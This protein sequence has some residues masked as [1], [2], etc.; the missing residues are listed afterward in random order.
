LGLA[1]AQ[2]IWLPVNSGL[3]HPD[4]FSLVQH[5][6]FLYAGTGGGGCFR[7]ADGGATWTAVN[8]GLT[9]LTIFSFV[10]KGS[11]LFCGTVGGGVHVSSDNGLTWT[12][13]NTGLTNLLIFSL[14]TDGTTLYAGTVGGGVFRS[15]DNGATWSASNTGLTNF[16]VFSLLVHGSRMYATTNGDGLFISN[17]GGMTWSPSNTGLTSFATCTIIAAGSK[18]YLGTFGGGAFESNDG[19]ITWSGIPTFAGMQ[20][21]RFTATIPGVVYVGTGGGGVFRTTDGGATWSTLNTGLTN[22]NVWALYTA[23]GNNVFAGTLG[24][25]AHYLFDPPFITTF[26]PAFALTGQTVTIT[27]GNFFLVSAVS[28]GGV[29][30]ASFTV[31]DRNT[32]VATVGAGASGQVEVTTPL[33]TASL[34]NFIFGTPPPPSTTG[35]GG[36]GGTTGPPPIRVLSFFPPSGS[37][38]STIVI[39]GQN[40]TSAVQVAFGGVTARSFVVEND[41]TIRA[42]V[43]RGASG[44]ITVFQSS[45]QRD[46]SKTPFEYIPPPQPE[47]RAIAPDR[48]TFATG[49]RI[50]GKNFTGAVAVTFGSFP[51]LSFRVE[52]DSV[53]TAVVG[54]GVAGTTRVTVFT[55]RAFGSFDGFTYE[56]LPAPIITELLP[57]TI[58][59]N[60]EDFTVSVIGRHFFGT[61]STVTLNNVRGT[62]LSIGPTEAFVR[63]PGFLRRVGNAVLQ[64]TNPDEQFTTATLR[65]TPAPAPTITELSVVSTMATGQAFTVRLKG[66]GFFRSSIITVNNVPRL[67]VR[68][69][70]STTATFE[71]SASE[72]ITPT[73]AVIRVINPDQQAAAAFLTILGHPAP[74]IDRLSAQPSL[75]DTSSI[76][77]RVEGRNF[78]QPAI[79]ELSGVA[80]EQVSFSPTTIV[81]IVP[82]RLQRPAGQTGD[83]P[84]VVIVRNPD[85]QIAGTRWH[86]E[87]PPPFAITDVSP[88]QR[89]LD[90]T[91]GTL[92]FGLTIRGTSFLPGMTAFLDSWWPLVVLR[93]TDT[94][95]FIQLPVPLPPADA[96]G[97]RRLQLRNVNGGV[98][99]HRLRFVFNLSGVL[100]ASELLDTSIADVTT[101]ASASEVMSEAE[102]CFVPLQVRV[103]PN[104]AT[105]ELT[106]RL[107]PALSENDKFSRTARIVHAQVRSM[108]SGKIMLAELP[109]NTL[110][111]PSTANVSTIHALTFPVSTLPPG[112]YLVELTV[113]GQVVHAQR[114]GAM[115]SPLSTSPSSNDACHTFVARFV[116]Q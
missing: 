105:T 10:S 68:D 27:G 24:G 33:G 76:W 85:G 84:A 104:P 86:V 4:V 96:Q 80:L 108:S 93:Q 82:P 7:S 11:L 30:A 62:I 98:A 89:F 69:R 46:T 109:P 51:A 81:A 48:G 114:S 26:T 71:I 39:L 91:T 88:V 97:F 35:T 6:G 66:T 38:D 99:E 112:A 102:L 83:L 87:R 52:N 14:V 72:N 43:G 74:A 65:I 90:A 113:C 107:A 53:I 78:W 49:V 70:S 29:P 5:N 34:M 110:Y 12:P 44:P 1:Q 3:A 9:N 111:A 95:A 25:G 92:H 13:T 63:F 50:F 57:S 2:N 77:M 40:F 61:T 8:T 100:A 106:V 94:T 28:F 36:S 32:I 22:P 19:G 116:K 47:I 16:Q 75:R 42:V 18:M 37:E 79:V 64:L 101:K 60:D 115:Q 41:S 55:R 56:L 103:Y 31:I 59:A 17:D 20:V 67:L 45:G 58:A 73:T 21:W 15:T 54:R 23:S